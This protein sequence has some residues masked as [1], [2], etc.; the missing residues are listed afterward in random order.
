[1]S[2]I[3]FSSVKDEK[4]KNA[5]CGSRNKRFSLEK[6]LENMHTE[7]QKCFE[8]TWLKNKTKLGDTPWD[9]KNVPIHI[10]TACLH[11]AVC[12]SFIIW[13][14]STDK[15]SFFMVSHYS[16]LYDYHHCCM[17]FGKAGLYS[18]VLFKICKDFSFENDFICVVPVYLPP[19]KFKPDSSTA[20]ITSCP[21]V[22]AVK[23]KCPSFVF[24][25]YFNEC[26]MVTLS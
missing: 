2:T 13:Y 17:W 20:L 1:M 5:T 7:I 18:N 11:H 21:K 3:F 23:C 24:S 12:V 9:K 25:R 14:S 26:Y 16:I 6:G 4:V 19:D 15:G 22:G 10:D 8:S